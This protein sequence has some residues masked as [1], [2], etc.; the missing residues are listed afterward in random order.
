M[1]CFGPTTLNAM[2]AAKAWPST[3]PYSVFESARDSRRDS[4][5]EQLKSLIDTVNVVAGVMMCIFKKHFI[6]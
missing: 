6:A 4:Q 2:S 5:L 1:L 3:S